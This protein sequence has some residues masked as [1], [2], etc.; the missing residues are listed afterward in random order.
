LFINTRG[1]ELRKSFIKRIQCLP[2]DY[3]FFEYNKDKKD[4]LG[5]SIILLQD[6]IQKKEKDDVKFNMK[7]L[8]HSDSFLNVENKEIQKKYFTDGKLNKILE[9]DK[10]SNEDFNEILFNICILDEV[11]GLNDLIKDSRFN[12]NYNFKTSKMNLLHLCAKYDSIKI[13]TILIKN[14][15]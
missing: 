13:S 10:I 15:K 2:S 6:I 3:D 9:F 12:I 5:D 14:G 1:K 11:D 4:P 7:N 8:I